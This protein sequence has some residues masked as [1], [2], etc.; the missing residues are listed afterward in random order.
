[1]SIKTWFIHF[2][3][4]ET[5]EEVDKRTE[6]KTNQT[7]N[8]VSDIVKEVLLSIPTIKG[9]EES[10]NT[11][12]RVNKE[13]NNDTWHNLYLQSQQKISELSHQLTEAKEIGGKEAIQR[14]L[15]DIVSKRKE[16]VESHGVGRPPKEGEKV[17]IRLDPDVKSR[18]DILQQWKGISRTDLINEAC[19][20][21]FTNIDP[22]NKT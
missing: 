21:Y 11:R 13:E 20:L 10:Q 22:D 6:L 15:A 17:S 5:S 19:R 4:G 16:L 18:L 3:G 1:M 12:L 7:K 2:F 9:K 8:L 14:Y